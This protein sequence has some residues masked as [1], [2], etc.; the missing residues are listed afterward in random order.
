LNLSGVASGNAQ[1]TEYRFDKDHNSY[2]HLGRSLREQRVAAALNLSDETKGRVRS[3][4]EKLESGDK[5]T[6]IQTLQ[7]LSKLGP[8]A[9][10]VLAS[11]VVL[12]QNTAD[13]EIRARAIEVAYGLNTQEVYSP[14]VVK[15]VEELSQLRSTAT[16]TE[17]VDGQGR[18]GLKLSI[19]GNGANV[20]VIEHDN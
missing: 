1:L 2:F 20:V 17:S 16:S 10:S 12:V 5:P 8:A 13:E 18:L 6:I 15:Q 19:S 11:L 3:A 7:E 9:K 14:D 4:I